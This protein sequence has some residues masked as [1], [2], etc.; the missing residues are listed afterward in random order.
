MAP[1]SDNNAFARQHMPALAPY[2]FAF[3]RDSVQQAIEAVLDQPAE[4]IA[5][6]E[7]TWEAL[8]TSFGLRRSAIQIA[9]FC[10]LHNLNA[11]FGV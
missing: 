7:E 6:T 4:A 1:I 3:T 2:S 10:T 5:H 9:Q 8:S 11:P